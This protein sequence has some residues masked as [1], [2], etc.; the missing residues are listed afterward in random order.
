MRVLS[1]CDK[2][3]DAAGSAGFGKISGK[4]SSLKKL[5]CKLS[6]LLNDVYSFPNT[7][8]HNNDVEY[9]FAFRPFVILHIYIYMSQFL[10]CCKYVEEDTS[11]F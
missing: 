8:S 3:M 1:I 11:I 7:T 2:V 6:I 9:L 4:P 10:L 5:F